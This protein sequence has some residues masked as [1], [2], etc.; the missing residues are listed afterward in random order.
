MNINPTPSPTNPKSSFSDIRSQSFER[1]RQRKHRKGTPFYQDFAQ[2][3]KEIIRARLNH[4]FDEYQFRPL[5]AIF[6]IARVSS[7]LYPLRPGKKIKN[8][9]SYIR[10]GITALYLER[11]EKAEQIFYNQDNL[12]IDALHVPGLA[13]VVLPAMLSK[14]VLIRFPFPDEE[15]N[16]IDNFYESSALV[17]QDSDEERILG[18]KGDP[19]HPVVQKQGIQEE[20][21]NVGRLMVMSELT[22]P[23]KL[24]GAI[25]Y[26]IINNVCTIL[27]IKIKKEFRRRGL[28]N[29]LLCY[30][31]LEAK[32]RGCSKVELTSTVKG[33]PLYVKFG[34][35]PNEEDEERWKALSDQEK[36][37]KIRDEI[38]SFFYF[39][40]NETTLPIIQLNL[41]K[42]LG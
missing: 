1:Y 35:I 15:E 34:F 20:N 39:A 18:Q 17:D 31:M 36:M 33:Y 10:A 32:E 7:P 28:G 5:R 40:L 27:S 24:I 19:V 23:D 12:H 22:H 11:V 6:N 26:E 37:Q 41:K 30:A 13:A 8:E 9:E 29:I 14:D 4:V 16:I 3:Y 2:R 25:H 38:P 21:G 42:S